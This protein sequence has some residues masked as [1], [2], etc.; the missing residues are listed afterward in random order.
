MLPVCV[1]HVFVYVGAD[2]RSTHATLCLGA[3]KH[4]PHQ[5]GFSVRLG[6]GLGFGISDGCLMCKPWIECSPTPGHLFWV[7]GRDWHDSGLL[8][9]R[10]ALFE[11]ELCIQLGR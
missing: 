6:F 4:P 11:L 7:E 3:H 10:Q 5:K 9:G 1:K 2:L 8:L